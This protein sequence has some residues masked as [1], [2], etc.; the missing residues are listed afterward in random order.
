GNPRIRGGTVDMGA[1]ERQ[2][3]LSEPFIVVAT[4]SATNLV[5]NVTGGSP[6]D[7]WDL[8]TSTNVALPLPGWTTVQSGF[9]D[10]RGNVVL[11]NLI[12]HGDPLRF[13]L[14]TVP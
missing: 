14:I 12:N 9:F 2:L 10:A 7:P 4:E 5:F 6:G 3:A 13:F 11:S 8:L 1:Y